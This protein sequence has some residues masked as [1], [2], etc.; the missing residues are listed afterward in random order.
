MPV[1]RGIGD[2]IG[3][4]RRIGISIRT[5]DEEYRWRMDVLEG[6]GENALIRVCYMDRDA[7]F[8]LSGDRPVS[9]RINNREM[10]E[11]ELESI[12]N[13]LMFPLYFFLRSQDEKVV[14]G[15]VDE[16]IG[17]IEP[18]GER[19]IL[20]MKARGF[21][22]RISDLA[23]RYLTDMKEAEYWLVKIGDYDV[24]VAIRGVFSQNNIVEVFLNSIELR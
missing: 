14:E 9:G 24:A 5:A 17:R 21:R 16:S 20:G 18:I 2:I 11:D 13:L 10:P 4:A 12:F 7:E 8:L 19:E 15:S 23:R 6:E 22:V 1:L 3:I